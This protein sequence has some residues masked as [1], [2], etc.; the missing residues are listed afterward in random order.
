[1]YDQSL[2]SETWR[3]EYP[4][5]TIVINDMYEI[6]LIEFDGVDFSLNPTLMPICLPETSSTDGTLIVTG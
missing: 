1:M 2:D 3:R 4:A 5:K 6:A